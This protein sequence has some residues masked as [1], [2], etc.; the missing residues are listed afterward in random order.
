MINIR[1]IIIYGDYDESNISY[2]NNYASDMTFPRS[3]KIY[4]VQDV[5][6]LL[7][8]C[9]EK[10]IPD[11]SG[12]VSSIN[13]FAITR[14]IDSQSLISAV[15]SYII[16]CIIRASEAGKLSS[17]FSKASFKAQLKFV[18]TQGVLQ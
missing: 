12:L 11:F 17:D 7:K 8:R 5:F 2:C 16:R 6:Q 14:G 13:A 9:Y 1:S 3:S 15:V 18:I 4:S 10:N